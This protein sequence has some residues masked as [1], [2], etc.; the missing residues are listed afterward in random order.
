G[1][2]VPL[3]WLLVVMR[4][5]GWSFNFYNVIAFPLLIGMGED[6]SLHI[7]HRYLEEGRGSLWRVVR[8]TGGAVFMAAWTTIVGYASLLFGHHKGLLTL[9]E[10]SITGIALCWLSSVVLMPSMLRVREWLQ[11]RREARRC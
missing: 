1:V 8:E 5:T 10:L 2:V 7:H 4:I 3:L 9:A 11:E 6:N